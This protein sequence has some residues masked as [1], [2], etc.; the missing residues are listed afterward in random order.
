MGDHS[1]IEWTNATWNPIG[2]CSMVGPECHGCYA[3]PVSHRLAANP[4]PKTSARH[5]G[6]TIVTDDG[7]LDWNGV[8]RLHSDEV[9]TQPM[10]WRAPRRIFVN[11]LSDLFHANLPDDAIAKV[12]AVMAVT[13]QHTYQ[14]LT[15]RPQR[16]GN[17]LTTD[18]FWYQVLA[19]A[20]RLQPGYDGSNFLFRH[21]A[22]VWL[23]TS[24]GLNR[25]SYR[26][27]HLRRTPA[28]VR[29]LSLEPLLEALPALELGFIDWVVVGG[30]S[31]QVHHRARPMDPAWVRDLR[32]RCTPT[33]RVTGHDHEGMTTEP[34]HRPAFFF[35]QWGDWAPAGRGMGMSKANEGREV[36]IGE[37]DADGCRQVMRRVGKKEAGRELDGRTWDEYPLP[38]SA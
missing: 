16:M 28:A 9:L 22:N 10:R 17:L 26:A 29:W 31:G 36:L 12:F 4:N 8:V 14:V 30:E 37:P 35:K 5:A 7:K 6:L 2:G 32:D 1:Q 23:G 27:D 24:I 19:H 38:R 11:S 34:Y 33:Y 21:L 18:E 13:P 20:E 25:S 15:K 3:I